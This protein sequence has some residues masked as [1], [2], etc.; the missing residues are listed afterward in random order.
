M[1]KFII[2]LF[3]IPLILFSCN[4]E[5]KIEQKPIKNN[6][7]QDKSIKETKSDVRKETEFNQE[8]FDNDLETLFKQTVK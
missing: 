2:L 6:I 7:E 3:I 8:N 4:K 5:N 1:K